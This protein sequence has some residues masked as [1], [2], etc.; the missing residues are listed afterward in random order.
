VSLPIFGEVPAWRRGAAAAQA[1]RHSAQL[2]AAPISNNRLAELAGVQSTALTEV[3][4]ARR[5]PKLSY[6]LDESPSVGKVVLHSKW[7]TGRRFELA[8]LLGDRIAGD[9]YGRLFPATRS[10][11]YRQKLQRTF[12]AE[13][14]CPFDTLR[15]F[16]NDDFSQEAI[17][18]ASEYFDVS[19]RTVRTSLVNHGLIERDELEA[20][21][22]LEPKVALYR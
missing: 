7:K 21:L 17:E 14:L 9:G 19:D 12:A 2:G 20:D 4:D 11:T 18:D 5:G 6:A 13:L 8:R 3:G 1:L 15:G 16:L 22:D 10:Y